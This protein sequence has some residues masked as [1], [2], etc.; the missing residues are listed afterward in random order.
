ME[1]INRYE[2]EQNT[3]FRRDWL[4]G[5]VV[6]SPNLPIDGEIVGDGSTSRKIITDFQI[7]P[8]AVGRD[9]L[10]FN[11]NG[12][13]RLYELR[14]NQPIQDIQITISFQTIYGD[15]RPLIVSKL[16]ECQIKLEFRPNAQVYSLTQDV[17]SFEY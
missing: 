12:G 8:S 3:G 10:I 17:S 4:N 7:D 13:M 2:E 5:I 14:S 15:I 6:L 16:T 1:Q 9:Y 11:N